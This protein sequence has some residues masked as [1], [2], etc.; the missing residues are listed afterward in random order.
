MKILVIFYPLDL[1]VASPKTKHH[2]REPG[3]Y[4]SYAIVLLIL[5]MIYYIHIWMS[6]TYAFIMLAQL[7]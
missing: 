7:L 3:D 4:E 2:I 1:S 6:F 5:R